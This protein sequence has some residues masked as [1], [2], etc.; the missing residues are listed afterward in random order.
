MAGRPPVE[1]LIARTGGDDPS[2]AAAAFDSVSRSVTLVCGGFRRP[3]AQLIAAASRWSGVP[4]LLPAVDEPLA[5]R[6]SP[7]AWAIG[8]AAEV[9]AKRLAEAMTLGAS[10]RVATLTSS[11]ADT[12]FAAGFVEAC[13][14][15]GAAIATRASYAPGNVSFAADVRAL[16]SQRVTVLFFDGDA[17]E[18]AALLRQ[19]TRDRV[20]LRICGGE[21]LDPARHHRESRVL[22]EGVRYVPMDWSLS[23]S[24]Q[25]AL[26]RDLTARGAGPAGPLHVRGWLAGR[27]AGAALATGV[28]TPAELAAAITRLSPEAGS[29]LRVLGVQTEGAELPVYSVTGGRATRQ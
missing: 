3:S 11:A 7:R 27:V 5:T 4:A 19:L 25:E 28:Y 23:P 9:R 16:V 8:P 24:A 14:R 18:A 6:L 22:L 13:L 26:D 21:G 20:S 2:E 1:C 15:S 17:A 29:S 12:A 10:D